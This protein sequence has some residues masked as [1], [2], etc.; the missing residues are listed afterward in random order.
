[1]LATWGRFVYRWRWPVL[2]L[3][4]VALVVSVFVMQLGL[5]QPAQAPIDAES[6]RGFNL[7]D[8]ELPHG[9]GSVSGFAFV[10]SS[11]SLTADQPAFKAAVTRALQPL[12]NDARV[13]SIRTPYDAPPALARPMESADLHHVLVFV[14]IKGEFNHALHTFPAVRGSVHS[15]TLN[16]VATDGLAVENDFNRV[17]DHDLQRAETFSAPLALLPL[18]VVFG[19]GIAALLPLGVG[20][21]SV[22][23]ALGGV[24]LLSRLTDVSQYAFNIV[25]LIGLGVGIDCSRFIVNRFREELR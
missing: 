19:L 14:T 22:V 4:C 2:A 17:L 12:R 7:L 23:G 10:F 21:L 11:D 24:V 15:D 13:V 8:D 5:V 18:I 20:A 16:I 1:M 6:G 25:T 3:S 9:N